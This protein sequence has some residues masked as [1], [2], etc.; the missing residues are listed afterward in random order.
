MSK[1][2]SGKRILFE[3]KSLEIRDYLLAHPKLGKKKIKIKELITQ[4]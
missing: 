1:P 4:Q 3:G 2:T